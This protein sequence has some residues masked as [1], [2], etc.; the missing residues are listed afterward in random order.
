MLKARQACRTEG[1]SDLSLKQVC[2]QL[3]CLGVCVCLFVCFVLTYG[4]FP[5]P[6]EMF[7]KKVCRAF[8]NT[9]VLVPGGRPGCWAESTWPPIPIGTSPPRSGLRKIPCVSLPP[10]AAS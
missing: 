8:C 3:G 7:S 5:S 10:P 9:T 1:E 6:L 4:H 2:L